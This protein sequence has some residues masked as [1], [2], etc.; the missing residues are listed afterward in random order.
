MFGLAQFAR[1]AAARA[2]KALKRRRLL[3]SEAVQSAARINAMI[4][5]NHDGTWTTGDGT[6]VRVQAMSDSHLFYAIAK[7]RRGEYPD[8]YSRR[9]GI[10][11]LEVEAL[12]RLIKV[13]GWNGGTE[14]NG[15]APKFK[16]AVDKALEEASRWGRY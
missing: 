3:E 10:R 11:A 13:V 7:G 15:R 14:K 6:R 8:S 1:D 5:E 9:T 12:R 4:R 16:V 2:E